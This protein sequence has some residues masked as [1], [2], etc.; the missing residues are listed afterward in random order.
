MVIHYEEAL[1][2]VYAPL[3]LPLHSD[4]KPMPAELM[5]QNLLS[6]VEC[7]RAHPKPAWTKYGTAACFELS[8]L[9]S[10]ETLIL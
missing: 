3:P 9:R 1:Y 2:Q 10:T 6:V 7:S 8:E 4:S 5:G